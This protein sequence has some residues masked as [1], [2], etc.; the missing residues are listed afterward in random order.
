MSSAT[1]VSKLSPVEYLELER[2][3]EQRHG[4]LVGGLVAMAGGSRARN[5]PVLGGAHRGDHAPTVANRGEALLP[6]DLLPGRRAALQGRWPGLE[7]S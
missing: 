7:T 3:A 5:L 1:T 6:S 2:D 4:Y